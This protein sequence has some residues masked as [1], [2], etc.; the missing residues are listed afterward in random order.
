MKNYLPLDILCGFLYLKSIITRKTAVY[1][2]ILLLSFT[3]YAQGPGCPNVNAGAD[4]ELPCD[5]GCTDLTATFLDTGETTSYEVTSIFYDPPFPFTGGTPVSANTDDVWSPAIPLPFDFCFFGTTYSEI[6]IGSNGVVSFDLVNNAPGG[7]C[8][9][10]FEPTETIPSP[11]DH[12]LATIFGPYMDIDPSVAGSGQINYS[13]FGDAPCRTMVI[14]FPDVPYFSA[15]CNALTLTSQVVIYETTN[16]IEVYVEDRSDACPTWNDGLAILG[17]QNQD[18]TIGYTPPG[19]NTGNWSAALEAWRF[20]PNGASNVEFAWLN[21]A[22]DVI[23]TDP[24][25]NVCPDD[26]I[27]NYT[28]QAIYTN[29]NGDVITETDTVTVTKVGGFTLELGEDQFFCDTPAYEIVP[30]LTGDT[31]GAT[32]LWSPGGETTP[33]ITV[34]TTGT[35]SVDVTVGTCTATDSVTI[36]FLTSPD[37]TIEP[38]C[39]DIDFEE[40][41]GTG[42]GRVCDLNGATTTYICNQVSQIEDGEYSISNISD[43]LNTGWHVGLEDHTE[44]D[45]DGRMLFVNAA[46]A[47]GEFYRRTITLNSNGDYSFSAWITTLYDTDTNICGGTSIPSNVIFRIETPAGDLIEETNTGDIPNG[48]DPVWQEFFINFNTGVNTDIQLVLINNS[49]GGCGN[50]LAIDDI[51]LSLQNG[52]PQIVEPQDLVACDVDNDDVENFDLESQIAEILDGQDPA[53]FNIT[54]HLSQFDAEANQNAIA[55]PDTYQNVSN[56]E[57]IYVRVEKV[58]EPSCF[59]TVDF[60]LILNEV[61][62]LSGNL[63][64]SVDLCSTESFPVLD[65]TPVD[66]NIDLSLV[67][68]VWTNGN[69]DIVS[70]TATFTPTQAGTYTVVVDYPP[71]SQEVFTVEVTVTETPILNLGSDQILCD[72]GSYEIIP[73]ITGNTTGISYLWSTGATTP[74]I[75]VNETGTYDLQIT[76]GPCVVSDSVEIFISDPLVV[77]LGPDFKTCPNEI[78]VLT[79]TSS[80]SDVTYQWFLNGAQINDE[81]GSTLQI[82]L[83][84]GD[85]GIQTYTVIITKDQCTGEDSIDVTLYDVSNCVIS[86]GLSPNGDGLNDS[87]DLT[88]LNDRTGISKLQIFNRHGLLVFEQNNYVNEWI[89]QSKNDNELPTGTYF[90][91]ID[92]LGNDPVY[93]PQ[94][95]GWIYLNKEGN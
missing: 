38:V 88:F 53:L 95:T 81:T 27:T 66:P 75:V 57:T 58:D 42:T 8:D 60:D 78:Q 40:N 69:G 50:D 11:T 73:T 23:G 93:G 90:Y 70:T 30:E 76:V 22:G 46:F 86:Q 19:R 64:S 94:A 91:V 85:T 54:F 9:W 24:T 87:L 63:P 14:N 17:I 80:E 15:S 55:T 10:S 48:P 29:C 67:T 59:N 31:T 2:S 62:D 84:E 20:T 39:G 65:A 5:E 47:P 36:T 74:T 7:F 28:A 82:T 3:S 44:G 83:N 51:T 41:F 33:T 45:V 52:Q 89:G 56:P 77:D 92:L 71:C 4:I 21:E 35:Y 1:F 61:F 34:S 49:I 79:A 25:I 37:C 32:Y 12:F 43:D 13:V 68:Y 72:G 26:P 16:V 18:G 6:V